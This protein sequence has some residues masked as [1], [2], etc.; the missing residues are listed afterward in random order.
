MDTSLI[1][2]IL[3]GV[4][5]VLLFIKNWKNSKN[6]L[7]PQEFKEKLKEQSGKIVDVRTKSEFKKEHLKKTD[8][9]FDINSGDF[10]QKV[11]SLHKNKTYYLY[12]RSGAR[13]GKAARVMKKNGFE[14]VYNIG[15]LQSLINAGFE[16]E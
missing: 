11:N 4:A 9:N 14:D 5:F 2:L 3:V 15:G 12:C 16:V 8:Y 1:I 10:E 13:S 6:A 7:S